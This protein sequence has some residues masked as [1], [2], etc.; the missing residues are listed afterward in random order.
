MQVEA[1]NVFCGELRE[2]SHSPWTGFCRDGCCNTGPHDV[3]SRTVCTRVTEEFL[4]FSRA[5]GNDLSTP[6]PRFQVPGLKSGDQ[7]CLCAA[8]WQEAFEA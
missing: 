2:G 8:R 7:W 6:V 1:K 3:G 5:R 4:L